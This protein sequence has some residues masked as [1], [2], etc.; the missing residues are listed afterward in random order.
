MCPRQRNIHFHEFVWPYR[1]V[2]SFLHSRKIPNFLNCSDLSSSLL[3][4]VQNVKLPSL[5]EAHCAQLDPL[6]S[7]GALGLCPGS[8]R[9]VVAS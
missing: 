4:L 8:R 1:L 7:A 5:S 6:L 2:R 9:I 3:T